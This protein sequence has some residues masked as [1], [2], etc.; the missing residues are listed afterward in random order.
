MVQLQTDLEAKKMTLVSQLNKVSDKIESY[1]ILDIA[2]DSWPLRD[3][4][5][6]RDYI[7]RELNKI[8]KQI[9]EEEKRTLSI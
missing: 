6:K 3:L 5:I 8:N 1:G 2:C 7:K 9:E 4:I